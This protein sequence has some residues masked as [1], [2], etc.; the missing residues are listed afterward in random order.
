MTGRLFTAV[1]VAA[2]VAVGAQAEQGPGGGGLGFSSWFS[3]ASSRSADV[4]NMIE[5]FAAGC[6]I[7]PWT[8]A[9]LSRSRSMTSVLQNLKGKAE[10]TGIDKSLNAASSL[11]NSLNTLAQSEDLT[12][13]AVM[14]E[15]LQ[16]MT[17][18]LQAPNL[19]EEQK[20]E[21]VKRYTETQV[22]LAQTRQKIQAQTDPT[23]KANVIKSVQNARGYLS[24][25][26]TESST[27]SECYSRN[28]SA[29]LQLASGI[30]EV[31]GSFLPNV[32]GMAIST[33]AKLTQVGVEF[34]RTLPISQK[35]YETYK[36]R[37]PLAMTCGLEVITR[38][39]CKARDA[40]LLVDLERHRDQKPTP[41][42]A[43]VDFVENGLPALNAWL[44]DVENGVKPA[45]QLQALQITKQFDRLNQ[46]NSQRRV[47]EGIIA[48]TRLNMQNSNDPE[49]RANYVKQMISKFVA[50]L[51]GNEQDPIFVGETAI[52]FIQKITNSNVQVIVGRE[53]I[54]DYISYA[55]SPSW[56]AD[57]IE[58]NLFNPDSGLF[59]KAYREVVRIF[60]ERVNIDPPRLIRAATAQKTD[61]VSPYG[62]ITQLLKFL[63]QYALDPRSNFASQERV[64]IETFRSQ[65][66]TVRDA[67]SKPE[68]TMSQL[69]PANKTGTSAEQTLALIYDTFKL[70]NSNVYVPG[71]VARLVS[72]DLTNRVCGG[73]G[74]KSVQDILILAGR[75]IAS[76]LALN[77]LTPY[78]V[79][80]DIDSAQALTSTT[81]LNF[82]SFFAKNVGWAIK[83]KISMADYNMEPK[84]GSGSAPNR[85]VAAQLCIMTLISGMEWPREVDIRLCKGLKIVSREAK[86]EMSFDEIFNR[87][88]NKSFEEHVC[89]YE[90]FLRVDQLAFTITKEYE[91]G[92]VCDARMD[93]LSEKQD[94]KLLQQSLL[95]SDRYS[96]QR[97][98]TAAKSVEETLNLDETQKAKV[99][100][101]FNQL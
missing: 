26:V 86:I 92:E 52:G 77:D 83:D 75:D 59:V 48:E 3:G 34:A 25:L 14:T 28:P 64:L 11:E 56:T 85:N 94:F 93:T 91:S 57:A 62:A 53:T 58:S 32:A 43:G 90:D 18:A 54:E 7:G 82:R 1:L 70:Q 35:I 63:D 96:A 46:A 44:F 21:I 19:G 15:Q 87:L 29:A 49:N 20:A 78:E 100:T 74:P 2:L 80:N 50:I 81:L 98:F 5:S 24:V 61:G 38:D 4:D 6:R 69:D 88:K 95:N 51:F 47:I 60:S 27:L 79:R 67:L 12:N 9:A 45:N 76:S 42:F 99:Q 23:A 17:I 72:D 65:L 13:E 39:Y 55:Y 71:R 37:M 40:R 97:P 22:Q 41:F 84:D 66:I 68:A 89:L 8:Q 101:L 36:A 33:V 10:C 73:E 31:A 16:D 30:G